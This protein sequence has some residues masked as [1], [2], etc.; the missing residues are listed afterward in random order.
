MVKL[1][2]IYDKIKPRVHCMHQLTDTNGIGEHRMTNESQIN[3]IRVHST[4]L[5]YSD[6]TRGVQEEP[7]I[8]LSRSTNY[9]SFEIDTKFSKLT[10]SSKDFG[11]DH[12]ASKGFQS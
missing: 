8:V 3:A 11:G 7:Q 5:L 12:K 1:N 4:N 9:F 6:W 10:Q 2:K